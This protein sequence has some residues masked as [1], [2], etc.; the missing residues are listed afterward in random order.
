MWT[1]HVQLDTSE[2]HTGYDTR[3]TNARQQQVAQVMRNI[4]ATDRQ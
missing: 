2:E 4:L 3:I 1:V